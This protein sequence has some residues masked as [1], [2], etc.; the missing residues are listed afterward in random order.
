MSDT[1]AD[2]DAGPDPDDAVAWQRRVDTWP[3]IAAYK[4]HAHALLAGLAPVIDVGC[5]P[6]EDIAAL[7]PQRAIGLDRSR[8]MARATR[9]AGL[10]VAVADAARLPLADESVAGIRADRVVQH[11]DDPGRVLAEVVRVVRPGGR[12]VLA[13]PD[14]GTLAIDVPGAPAG[15]T[16]VVRDLRRD[17][18]Y[19]HGRVAATYGERLVAL[20]LDDVTV[21]RFPLVL[22]EP[23]D[24]FGLATWPRHWDEAGVHRWAEADLVRWEQAVTA[25]RAG[26]RYAVTYVVAAGRR[27]A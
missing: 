16:E 17:V 22:D 25:P 15:M 4:A 12:V 20:G 18:G 26:F 14:Q 19:R 21:A 7:G 6:G 23:A 8:T 2:V 3:A 27:P 9:T 10:T 13:D 11:V 5:G 1:Y 24:A